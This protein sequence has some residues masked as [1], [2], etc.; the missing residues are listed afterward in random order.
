MDL[1]E[2]A[3]SN[4]LLFARNSINQ[5]AHPFPR[6]Q[7]AF[8]TS[9]WFI[10][11]LLHSIRVMTENQMQDTSS[12]L[13]CS[14]NSKFI[15]T[16]EFVSWF[17]NSHFNC[18]SIVFNNVTTDNKCDLAFE[19]SKMKDQSGEKSIKRLQLGT[20]YHQHARRD[21]RRIFWRHHTFLEFHFLVFQII[22]P[23]SPED[24]NVLEFRTNW[25]C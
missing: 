23:W 19:K 16:S 2:N 6:R 10:Q 7:C 22:Q 11:I 24:I 21:H 3:H 20:C 1:D 15:Q 14:M 12:C 9:I 4:S 8:C 5:N 18:W 17:E 13:L 25:L